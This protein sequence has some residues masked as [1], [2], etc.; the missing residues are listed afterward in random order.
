MRERLGRLAYRAG[1]LAVSTGSLVLRP[2]TRG[3]K[4]LVTCGDEVLLVR[5]SYGPRVWDAP[6]GYARRGERYA[7][8][9]RRELTEE[10]G[11]GEITSLTEAGEVH[12]RLHGRHEKIGLVA[13]EL[14]DRAVGIDG[15]EVVRAGWFAP[16]DLPAARG[17]LVDALLAHGRGL[18]PSGGG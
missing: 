18:S 14:P 2:H 3:V 5:H 16:D 1:Y 12:R 9:A 8:A 17:A 13:V 7:D 11:V 4:C 6:G 15:V 10:L